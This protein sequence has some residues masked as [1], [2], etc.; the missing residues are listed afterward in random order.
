MNR[1]E[2]LKLLFAG[3]LGTGLLMTACSPEEKA[4]ELSPKIVGTPGGRIPEEIERDNSLLSDKFF[5]EE[6]LALVTVLV[7]IVIP[8]DAVSGSASEAKVPEYIEF[9]MKDQP[10]NQTAFRGGLMW[11][12]LQ[13]NER[14]SKPFVELSES[15]RMEIIDEI[16]WPDKAA[17]GSEPGVKFFNLLRNMTVS[18]FYTTEMGFKDIGYVGNTPNVWDGVSQEVMDQYGLA[19]DEKYLNVYLTP[20]GRGSIATWDDQGNLIS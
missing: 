16:A 1:R 10:G 11:V 4:A 6:E 9:M 17:K 2:N 12:N 13:A 5:T 20:E 19:L 7:D 14:F 3:S 8:K 18:G 15:Q